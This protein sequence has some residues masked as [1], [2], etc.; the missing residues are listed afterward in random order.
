MAIETAH[1]TA[2]CVR[3]GLKM[4]VLIEKR[5]TKR[6]KIGAY[7]LCKSRK[8]VHLLPLARL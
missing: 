5:E 7:V 3:T 2:P 4:R 8:K 1:L 6:A